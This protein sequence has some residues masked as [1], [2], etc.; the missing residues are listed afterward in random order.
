[1]ADDFEI[2]FR[3]DD[4]GLATFLKKINNRTK[5][6]TKSNQ[7]LEQST[8]TLNRAT[9][10]QID[11]SVGIVAGRG[12]ELLQLKEFSKRNHEGAK[13]IDKLTI[14][15]NEQNIA[16]IK[17]RDAKRT[18]AIETKKEELANKKVFQSLKE[19]ILQRE[20][21]RIATEKQLIAKEKQRKKEIALLKKQQ[22]A[23]KQL[24]Q[25]QKL[26]R[27]QMQIM[28]ASVKAAGTTFQKLGINLNTVKLALRGNSTALGQMSKAMSIAR[29]KTVQLNK[30]MLNITNGGRLLDNSFATIRSKLLLVSFA[31]GLVSNAIVRQVK[32][33]A[34]QEDSVM[35]MAR[36]FGVDAANSL[37]GFSS[38]MQ[39]VSIFGDEVINSVIATMGSFGANEEQAKKLT[40]AT[41]DLASGLGLDLNSAGLLVAKSFGSSTNALARYGIEVDSSLKGQERMAAITEGVKEKFGELAEVMAMTTS[42]QLA[43]ASNAFGD[44]QERLGQA[45]APSILLVAKALKTFSNMIP[46]GLLKAMVSSILGLATGYGTYRIILSATTKGQMLHTAAMGI[47]RAKTFLFIAATHGL[48]VAMQGLNTVTKA[49]PYV[50][51]ASVLIGA[52]TAIGSLF[53]AT[54]G[55]TTKE[56]ELQER[57]KS[58]AEQKG[59]D[60]KLDAEKLQSIVENTD[61]IQKEI[62]TLTAKRDLDGFMLDLKLMEIDLGRQ[63][64]PLEKERLQTLFNLKVAL[65]KQ[66]E[67]EKDA[68]KLK[69]EK[70]ALE[71]RAKQSLEDNITNLEKQ[72]QALLAKLMLDGTALKIRLAEIEAGREL[73]KTEKEL[74]ATIGTLQ[75]IYDKNNE[76]IEKEITIQDI[77][78]EAYNQTREARLKLMETQIAEATVLAGKGELNANEL[79]GLFSLVQAYNELNEVKKESNKD[80]EKAAKIKE[81]LLK[82]EIALNKQI[83]N[84]SIQ[85]G[86]SHSN[87]GNA[88][89]AA[90]KQVI[91]AKLQEAVTTYMAGAMAKIPFPLNIGVPALGAA[92]FGALSSVLS[93]SS[94]SG[95]SSSSGSGSS[96][97]GQYAEGGYVGGN[98]HSQGG[99]LIE[100]ERGEFVMSRNAV[101]S[102]GLETLNQMNQSGGGGSIN[103]SVTGNV[104]TQDFVEGEL[105]ES[106]KEAVRR[107]SDFGI[108]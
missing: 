86:K 47:A 8:N 5:E 43:Q 63:L 27:K 13:N 12:K 57:L 58:L 64:D 84:A 72:K 6:A 4:G 2:K 92:M 14:A 75:A 42:G 67:I 71:E 29:I 19:V 106:I 37:D 87:A 79:A 101:E 32:M 85:I 17:G 65:E 40:K 99:T 10:R 36:V 11:A 18:N 103:V 91:I 54:S 60:L 105:A 51:L 81:T 97:I 70:A 90:A 28:T 22:A 21:D 39:E 48:T 38:A 49:N 46:L 23:E 96:P 76:K 45:L 34:E 104:L 102:I 15:L 62:D 88:A 100:A 69:K 61:A 35:K 25:S 78:A 44:L 9:Q 89:A 3:V 73:T 82:K 108:S 66:K 16:T 50:L 7:K 53:N 107:G 94:S 52:V 98:R 83:L 95:T 77:L 80:D 68:I 30:G 24:A 33:F 31:F 55:L 41:L 93:G 1:M 74:L 59:L 56:K 26:I 20:K